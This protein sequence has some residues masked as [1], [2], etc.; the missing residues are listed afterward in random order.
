[1]NTCTLPAMS[2]AGHAASASVGTT[3]LMHTE[4]MEYLENESLTPH[5]QGLRRDNDTSPALDY[6]DINKID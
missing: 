5:S 6:R 3:I 4:L 2:N 1:M